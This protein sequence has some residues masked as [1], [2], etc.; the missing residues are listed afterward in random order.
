MALTAIL[1]D[2][3]LEELFGLLE[4]GKRSGALRVSGGGRECLL[5]L[6]EGQ[7]AVQAASSGDAIMATATDLVGVLE[8]G[9]E[10]ARFTPATGGLA[11][12]DDGTVAD[13]RV[14]IAPA[15]VLERVQ[16]IATEWERIRS[17]IPSMETTLA[18]SRR[19]IAGGEPMT[20]TSEEWAAVFALAQPRAVREVCAELERGSLEGC[21]VLVSMIAKGLVEVTAIPLKAATPAGEDAP[22]EL[23]V[24]GVEDVLAEVTA[25]MTGVPKRQVRRNMAT[26]T[27]ADDEGLPAE[28]QAYMTRLDERA[29]SGNE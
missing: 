18:L 9:V 26:G 23:I 13:G 1:D 15:R 28:W 14:K 8:T 29:S 19:P 17:V 7:F 4:S 16:A 22:T 10:L 25:E 24:R 20:L 27:L 2:L 21:R 12:A 6:A 5:D 3:S 11:G